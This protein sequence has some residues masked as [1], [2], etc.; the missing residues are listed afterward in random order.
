MTNITHEHL[1][2]HGTYE[3][4]RAAKGRL[5]AGLSQ[6][7]EKSINP[8]RA[9]VLNRDDASYEY[10]QEITQVRQVSYGLGEGADVRA[11]QIQEKPD[12]IEFRASGKDTHGRLFDFPVRTQSRWQVQRLQLPG[13]GRGGH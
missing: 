6:S 10:L 8:P 5:F 2:Y 11:S 7:A 4:Y 13:G 3:N 1:D 12:G 9:A